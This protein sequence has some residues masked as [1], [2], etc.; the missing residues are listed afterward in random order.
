MT[1][2]RWIEFV[3]DGC[4]AVVVSQ[5]FGVIERGLCQGCA[6]KA[7]RRPTIEPDDP[8]VLRRAAR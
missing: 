5:S 7:D 8:E 1:A 6:E 4:G 3:C 2:D